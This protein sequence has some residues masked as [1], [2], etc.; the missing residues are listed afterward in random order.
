METVTEVVLGSAGGEEEGQLGYT[1]YG[2]KQ[3]QQ[4]LQMRPSHVCQ[5]F[6]FF[7]Y[8]LFVFS[9]PASMSPISLGQISIPRPSPKCVKVAS[10]SQKTLLFL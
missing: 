1:V 9:A 10:T 2:L 4:K 7:F 6:F 5:S 3:R 8:C